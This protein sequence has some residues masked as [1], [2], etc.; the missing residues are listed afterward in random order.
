MARFFGYEL[1]DRLCL[2]EDMIERGEVYQGYH[3]NYTKSEKVEKVV[4]SKK[5]K[6]ADLIKAVSSDKTWKEIASELGVSISALRFK[7]DQFGIKKE[8]L[9]KHS[10]AKGKAK[11]TQPKVRESKISKEDLSIAIKEFGSMK[12]LCLRFDVCKSVLRNT[13]LKYDLYFEC[14]D[15]FDAIQRPNAIQRPVAHAYVPANKIMISKED[16][17]NS[18]IELV[19]IKK[20][21]KR[22][23]VSVHVIKD[24]LSKFGL[25]DKYKILYHSRFDGMT[26]QFKG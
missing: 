26:C 17:E 7:C 9:H 5:L 23:N 14:R 2:I 21:A 13:L 12:E 24:R 20:M 19:S 16:F 22:F 1:D 4:Q 25:V 18:L 6:E 10:K 15:R 8:K 11:P 3:S